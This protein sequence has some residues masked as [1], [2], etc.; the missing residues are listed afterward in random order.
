MPATKAMPV[1]SKFQEALSK[2]P[3][4]EQHYSKMYFE[5]KA[6]LERLETWKRDFMVAKGIPV[7]SPP[8]TPRWA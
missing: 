4:A 1:R 3:A 5:T 6:Q 2:D 7:D 8:A